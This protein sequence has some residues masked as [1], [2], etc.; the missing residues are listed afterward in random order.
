[1]DPHYKRFPQPNEP[2]MSE[3][4]VSFAADRKTREDVDRTS[5][6]RTACRADGDVEEKKSRMLHLSM[7]QTQYPFS[8]LDFPSM[9]DLVACLFC[10]SSTGVPADLARLKGGLGEEHARLVVLAVHL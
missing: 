2:G 7:L 6:S 9:S 4:R 1:M 5:T 10:L 8:F 3:P